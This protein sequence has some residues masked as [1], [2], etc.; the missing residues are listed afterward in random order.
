MSEDQ[1]LALTGMLGALTLVGASLIARRLPM[2]T[3]G[4]LALIWVTIFAGLFLIAGAF[5]ALV[6]RFT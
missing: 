4:R 3:F 2:R 6:A 5:P 1:A